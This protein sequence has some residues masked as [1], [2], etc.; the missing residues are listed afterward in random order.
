[1]NLSLQDLQAVAATTGFPTETLDKVIRLMGLLDAFRNHP[2]LKEHVA[3][4][5]GTALNLFVF[6][7]PRLSVDI[8]LNEKNCGWALSC[9]VRAAAKI[10]ELFLWMTSVAT[11]ENSNSNLSLFYAVMPFLRRT[12]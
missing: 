3:L 11:G 9:M 5:G 12:R 2:L 1:M 4:K 8:D 10:G 7:L 6:D